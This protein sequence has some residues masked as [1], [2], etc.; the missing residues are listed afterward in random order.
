MMRASSSVIRIRIITAGILLLALLLSVRLYFVQL[1][2]G[3]YYEER[4]QN[5]YV[6]PV[7]NLF[8]RGSIYFTTKDRNRVSAATLKTGFTL[9]INPSVINNPE[10]VYKEI[11]KVSPID[12]EIFFA[13]AAKTSDPYEEIKHRISKEE[14]DAISELG[15]K[16]VQ[17]YRDRW[18]YYPGD[19]LESQTIGF[20]A[21][22]GDELTGRYGLERYYNDFLIRDSKD[23]FVNFF[24]EIFDNLGTLVFDTG[25]D[26]EANIVTSIEPTVARTLETELQK[27]HEKW[28]SNLTGGIVIN[29]KTGDIYALA[30]YPN[31]DLN[32]FAAVPDARY[33]QNP[34]I[35]SVYEMGSII[36]PLTMASGLD[37]GAIT[38]QST[39]YD[40]GSIELSGYT[41]SNYDGK[42]RGTVPMQEILNQS[43]NTGVA[44]IVERMGKERFKKY[45]EAFEF[46]SE[47]G[48]D[49]PGEA[50]GLVENMNS[51]RLLEF[52]NMSFGQGIALTPVATAR[53]LS[54][55]GNGG[56]LITPHV[57]QEIEYEN[58]KVH[59]VLFPEEERVFSEETSEEITR[60]LV[61]VVDT[62]LAG[63]NEKLEHYTIAAK[64]GTAQIAN[65][66]D[67]GYYD[68]R[69]LHSFF[70]YFPAYDPEFLIFLYT[71][72]PKEVRYASQTLTEPFMTLTRF[73]INYYNIPPDR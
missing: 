24:A 15:I 54:T 34:L 1:A 16:G 26:H 65:A 33:F 53:A 68:D 10:H 21:Y 62:A 29:P 63:G 41:I 6:R 39:Y 49:L 69:F 30:A 4:A 71:V 36:K 8:D 27:V 17:L 25:V 3:S 11:H 47:T 18:R 13:R 73:L 43:L 67:G 55:L 64:T 44:T 28:N 9:A 48:V 38:P 46:G 31:F 66:E 70:G 5:Q 50:H 61:E 57:A 51:P 58:G 45:F 14:A 2:H 59:E 56:R 72:E 7:N 22:D 42:G 37:S 35:E 60:M 19:T 20:V 52:A 12:S 23:L 40:A 32:D